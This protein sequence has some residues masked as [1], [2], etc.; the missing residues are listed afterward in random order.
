MQL[1][2]S[3]TVWVDYLRSFIT[4]LVVAHHSSLAYTTFAK[5]DK[6]AYIR[7]T[8]AIVDSA[9]WVGL[10]IFENFNDVFFMS[11]MFFIA[12][13]FL[14]KSIQKK[15][16]FD[17]VKERFYRLFIPF[18]LG[19]TLINLIAHYPS[20]Y[21]AHGES[22]FKAYII[23]FFEVEKWP[24]GPPWFIWVLF[25]FNVLFALSFYL[26]PEWPD[27]FSS[28]L[29]RIKSK[30]TYLIAFWFLFTF[31][32]YVPIAFWIGAGTWTGF[33][34]FD[35]QLSRI[36][37]YLGYFLFGAVVGNANFNEGMFSTQSSLV[38]NW[39][40]WIFLCLAV[41]VVLILVPGSLTGLV[42]EQKITEFFGYLIYYSIYVAS[43]TFSCITFLTTF[44]ALV[45]RQKALWNSL[46]EN[47][48]LIY[49]LHY[50]F[51]IWCQFLLLGVDIHASVKFVITFV[52]AVSASWLLS[53]LIRKNAVF[54]RY[55]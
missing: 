12:G 45:H 48:Y 23:D 51:V 50:V 16:A 49:L 5:F 3:R 36:A 37:L 55:L 53:I 52:V 18:I 28:F 17:F 20:Y 15:G 25:L 2:T 24:V 29:A 11:L 38:R 8:H 21:V 22:T 9:R 6:T 47:A 54:Q 13:L 1:S 41:Y 33:G 26:V 39:R 10:D 32:L 14:V 30:P 35:F 44:R 46:S 43:C 19:G 4:V 34:P 42:K 7:S 31:V 27:K 40:L